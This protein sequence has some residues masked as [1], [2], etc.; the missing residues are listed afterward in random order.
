MRAI[1]CIVVFAAGMVATAQDLN[2]QP[3]KM[4]A[5]IG[6]QDASAKGYLRLIASKDLSLTLLGSDLRTSAGDTIY[7]NAVSISGEAALKKGQ[8]KDLPVQIDGIRKP[9][10]YEGVIDLYA[11]SDSQHPEGAHYSANVILVATTVPKLALLGTQPIAW[12]L[13]HCTNWV[14]CAMVDRLLPS[15]MRQDEKTATVEDQHNGGTVVD[16]Q[17]LTTN[18]NGG[19]M[20]AKVKAEQRQDSNRYQLTVTFNR[21]QVAP[22]VYPA[23]LEARAHGRDEVLSVPVSLDV[24]IGPCVALIAIVVGVVIGRL[25]QIL[26]TPL[27]QFQSG[28]LSR[29]YQLRN[30]AEGVEDRALRTLLL[31]RVTNAIERIELANAADTAITTDV[32]AIAAL[33]LLSMRFDRLVKLIKQV[34]DRTKREGL[35]KQT[36]D[37][38]ELLLKGQT[39][40][41]E[42]QLNNAESEVGAPRMRS[43]AAEAM[44]GAGGRTSQA[45]ER[46]SLIVRIF[47]FLAG[48]RGPTPA[49]VKYAVVKPLLFF[50][51]LVVLCLTGFNTLYVKAPAGFGSAGLF[52]LLGLFM[53]GLTADVAQST[54]QRLPK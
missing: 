8:P 24:R 4:T 52:D 53:W 28:L 3:V 51:L 47:R 21:D 34:S 40:D 39:K 35:E 54:L 43:L 5:T 15:V 16:A 7:R 46:G 13:V 27:F 33:T 6:D 25:S 50:V 2:V 32:D 45:E 14:S 44:R 37:I 38:R 30:E 20:S 17:L 31:E 22:G 48:T 9:G 36:N 18:S 19:A 42:T 12:S 41:A 23:I 11:A 1:I 26:A 49:R 10:T 29:V